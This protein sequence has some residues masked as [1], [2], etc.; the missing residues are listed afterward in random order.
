MEDKFETSNKQLE[1]IYKQMKNIYEKLS[2]DNKDIKSYAN[3]NS[4]W[5]QFLPAV[6]MMKNIELLNKEMEGLLKLL[7][8]TEIEAP[9]ETVSHKED[10]GKAILES[11]YKNIETE[12][13][14]ELAA[15]II[16][17]RDQILIA[18][19]SCNEMQKNMLNNLNEEL[20]RILKSNG[21][22]ELPFEK[23][24]N[25]E[26]QAIVDVKIT[27]IKELD[28]TVAEICRPGYRR[29]GKI[30][31]AQEVVIYKCEML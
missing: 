29:N 23:A 31:R 8:E 13:P 24:F 4:L 17:L 10:H 14:G 1:D 25:K 27:D 3:K 11:K 30:I 22:D 26:L 5:E 18:K 12:N 19:L 20:G 9:K 21:I 15:D 7:K 16:K 6:L 2:H 28:N